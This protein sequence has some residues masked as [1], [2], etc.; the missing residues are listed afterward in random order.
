[1]ANKRPSSQWSDPVVIETGDLEIGAVEIKDATTANRVAVNASGAI[2]EYKPSAVIQ[3]MVS[4][5][6]GFSTQ[7]PANTMTE[8][9]VYA[10]AGNATTCYMGN[11]NATYSQC[12]GIPVNTSTPMIRANNTNLFYLS[13]SDT[14]EIRFI[15]TN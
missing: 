2:A 4:C 1:M 13:G 10:S 9:S 7:F 15:G 3:G 11:S 6:S 14:S 8:F 5:A 12:F